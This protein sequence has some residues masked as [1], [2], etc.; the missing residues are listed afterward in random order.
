MEAARNHA[1]NEITPS[2]PAAEWRFIIQSTTPRKNAS[3]S[4][5]LISDYRRRQRQRL[6]SIHRGYCAK[7]HKQRKILL[8]MA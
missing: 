5:P 4:A 6:S 2:A 3:A 7:P 8:S 1:Q